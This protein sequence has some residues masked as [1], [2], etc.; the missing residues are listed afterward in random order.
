V[1]F[2]RRHA[3]PLAAGLAAAAVAFAVIAL[4]TGDEAERPTSAGGVAA[5]GGVATQGGVAAQGA[6]A[7]PDGLAVFNRMGC[8][9]CHELAAAGSSGPVGPS[10]DQEL[11][12]HTRESLRVAILSP[13]PM[14]MMPEDFGERLSEAELSAL[15]EFLLASR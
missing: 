9:G 5:E 15:I 6:G 8:G 12:G 2:V 11:P 4:T 13:P 1:N 10:L 3:V 7:A 14:A